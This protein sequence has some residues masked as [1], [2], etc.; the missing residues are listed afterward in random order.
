MFFIGTHR[1]VLPWKVAHHPVGGFVSFRQDC[2][3][4]QAIRLLGAI[5]WLDIAQLPNAL[6][7]LLLFLRGRKQNII[8]DES[9]T[10]GVLM[11]A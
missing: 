4:E 2:I 6:C 8:E 11:Q 5:G 3:I 10:G 7:F 1:R 9:V